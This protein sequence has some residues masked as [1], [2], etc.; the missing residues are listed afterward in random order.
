MFKPI[1]AV[2]RFDI[3]RHHRGEAAVDHGFGPYYATG[4]CE[5]AYPSPPCGFLDTELVLSEPAVSSKYCYTIGTN[6][7]L[8]SI[9]ELSRNFKFSPCYKLRIA[10]E[11]RVDKWYDECI[12]DI[13][14]LPCMEFNEDDIRDLGDEIEAIS[15]VE[16]V[17]F[18][19]KDDEFKNL[20][21]DMGEQGKAWELY[22]QDN[23]LNHAYIVKEYS[24]DEDNAIEQEYASLVQK[25]RG[26]FKNAVLPSS[27]R[28]YC[29]TQTIEL[30]Y[31]PVI[32]GGYSPT[33]FSLS[34]VSATRPS[35]QRKIVHSTA[36]MS[37]P[38]LVN[39][40][41]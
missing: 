11:C 16:S 28:W 32:S 18:S 24:L 10:W 20:I 9:R 4:V 36:S 2:H 33:A 5:H 21:E 41:R 37:W 12:L 6:V 22:E 31:I 15:G 1:L 13:I 17:E 34:F 27:D 8:R 7:A 35:L 30:A 3:I 39:P 23:P 29:E 38:A 19:S 40:G 25:L 14:A 26:I